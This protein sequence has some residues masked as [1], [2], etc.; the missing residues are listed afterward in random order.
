MRKKSLLSKLNPRMKYRGIRGI[1]YNEDG[2]SAIE[3][4]IVAPLLVVL[5]FGCIELSLM[6]RLDRKVATT[7]SSLGDLTARLSS[8]DDSQMAEMFAAAGVL[9]QPNDITQSRMRI[10]SIV[11]D[12]DGVAKVAWSDAYNFTAMPTGSTV[13]VP[14]GIVSSPGSVILAE[15]EYDYAN[16]FGSFLDIGGTLSDRFYLRPRRV[17]KIPRVRDGGGGSAFGPVS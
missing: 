13:S 5:F 4:A 3:F 7:S 6:M 16:R 10:T 17:E 12:G 14:N 1:R 2:L 8:V 9:L 15:V 11:D